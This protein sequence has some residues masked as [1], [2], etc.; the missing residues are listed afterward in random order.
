MFL[1]R[2]LLRWW[3][4]H[5]STII[6]CGV[7]GGKTWDIGA[8][9]QSKVLALSGILALSGAR[10]RFGGLV[11]S[12]QWEFGFFDGEDASADIFCPQ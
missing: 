6:Q 1:I 11:P 12:V 3:G 8:L 5:E 7:G 2:H 4:T 9:P 10:H